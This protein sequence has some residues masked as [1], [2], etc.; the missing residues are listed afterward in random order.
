MLRLGTFETADDDP[1]L[2]AVS[3]ALIT[4][5]LGDLVSERLAHGGVGFAVEQ[6]C[7]ALV[8]ETPRIAHAYVDRLIDCG[9][10]IEA[11]Y[12]TYI[13]RAAAR[14]GEL[15][16]E[17]RLGFTAV[18]LG[19]ARLTELFRRVRPTFLSGGPSR[20][21]AERVG[22]ALFALAPGET[23]AL[24][25]VMA[26]D[27]FQR[28]GWSVRVELRSD[29][30]HLA[31]TLRGDAFDVVGLSAGSRRMIPAVRDAVARMRDVAPPSTRFLLGGALTSLDPD[32]GALT[33]V[34]HAPRGVSEALEA[35]GRGA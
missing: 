5:A 13:P 6:L 31:E 21:D 2:Y 35:L 7:A 16:L 24:G 22:S 19:M 29:A 15:W 11:I 9:V 32:A 10:S 28:H 34:D 33:G 27:C 26:A 20:P 14:L 23:H 12:G 4:R 3:P 1:G 18:T 25:V 17:D 8:E 30:R